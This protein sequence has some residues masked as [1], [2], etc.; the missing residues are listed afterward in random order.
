MGKLIY[1][2]EDG[3]CPEFQDPEDGSTFQ[4]CYEVNETYNTRFGVISTAYEESRAD[5]CAL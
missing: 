1:R 5:A 4:S 2:G 3:R